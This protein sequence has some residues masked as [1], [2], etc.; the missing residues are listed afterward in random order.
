[1]TSMECS[2]HNGT[3]IPPLADMVTGFDSTDLKSCPFCGFRTA[4]LVIFDEE[5]YVFGK[6]AMDNE[7][8][9]TVSRDDEGVPDMDQLIAYWKE[10]I[11]EVADHYGIECYECGAIVFGHSPNYAKG[12][13]NRRSYN[14]HEWRSAFAPR[15][16]VE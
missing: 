12:K 13:W 2:N 10:H 15:R 14:V 9:E 8:D 4:H 11:E 7:C 6:E 5:G 1:M 3:T 16:D